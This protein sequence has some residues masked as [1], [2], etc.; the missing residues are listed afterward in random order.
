MARRTTIFSRSSRSRSRTQ[1][2]RRSL[3]SAMSRAETTRC[4]PC[5]CR[6]RRGA[7]RTSSRRPRRRSLQATRL[8]LRRDFWT[9][10]SSAASTKSLL[11]TS[12]RC[13]STRCTWSTSHG[14]RWFR[15]SCR[16]SPLHESRL[17]ATDLSRRS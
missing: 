11:R 8:R 1:R 12:T 2:A 4:A 13:S 17:F 15:A 10:L 5:A 3:R 6:R 16:E 7:P 9:I 14:S